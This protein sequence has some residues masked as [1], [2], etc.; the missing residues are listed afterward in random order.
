MAGSGRRRSRPRRA[1]I[2]K[3][4]IKQIDRN[5]A[6]S[7]FDAD[8]HPS[9]LSRSPPPS[10]PRQFAVSS[11]LRAENFTG[12]RMRWSREVS[13][14]PI[15]EQILSL[16][17]AIHTQVLLSA[18]IRSIHGT[19]WGASK[20]RRRS[21]ARCETEHLPIGICRGEFVCAHYSNGDHAGAGRHTCRW[22]DG[23]ARPRP[24]DHTV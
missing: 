3:S 17:F 22:N 4:R 2:S 23:L 13:P 18:Q 21:C 9:V 1:M 11:A 5:R 15:G 20:S 12:P 6:G 14:I 16:A 8:S 24:E 19:I 10:Q 7:G